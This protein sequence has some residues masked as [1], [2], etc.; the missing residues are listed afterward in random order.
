[1]LVGVA[2]DTGLMLL[3]LRFL[4]GVSLPTHDLVQG[5]LLGGVGFTVLKLLGARLVSGT[6][7]NPLFA[8]IALVVGLL[9]WLNLIARLTLISAAW[10]ANDV[11]VGPRRCRACRWG[12]RRRGSRCA[13]SASLPDVRGPGRRPHDAGR[14]GGAGSHRRHGARLARAWPRGSAATRALTPYLG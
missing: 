1:M 7:N 13:R 14:G 5:A 12:R 2:V 6:V 4:S 8:S 10:A 9:V 3:L 11:G